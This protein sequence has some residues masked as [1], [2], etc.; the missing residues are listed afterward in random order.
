MRAI[1]C[2][3]NNKLMLFRVWLRRPSSRV[4][5]QT[6]QRG[7]TQKRS[8]RSTSSFQTMTMLCACM[9]LRRLLNLT[10]CIW[11]TAT[12][13]T[14][15]QTKFS[16]WVNF[17]YQMSQFHFVDFYPTWLT[18]IRSETH[19]YWWQLKT[20]IV[21]RRYLEWTPLHPLRRCS[22][23]RHKSRERSEA[24]CRRARRIPNS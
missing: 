5:S 12:R 19:A 9:R 1:A 23:C 10:T 15:L 24:I 17:L 6:R 13:A 4:N 21:R 20:R 11:S 14:H 22:P 18:I 2:P 16:R 3:L 8:P 7:S